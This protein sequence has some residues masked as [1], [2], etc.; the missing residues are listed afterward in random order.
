VFFD[1]VDGKANPLKTKG[2]GEPGINAVGAILANAAYKACR[3]RVY[4]TTR[5]R[6]TR[7]LRA[8]PESD[9]SAGAA[10]ARFLVIRA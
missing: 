6:W 1:E 7:R 4:A 5:L 9:R 3:V 10:P 2:A 8:W